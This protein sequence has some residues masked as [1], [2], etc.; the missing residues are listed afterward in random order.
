MSRWFQ[1]LPD[2]SNCIQRDATKFLQELQT[3][4]FYVNYNSTPWQDSRE[5]DEAQEVLT[6]LSLVFSET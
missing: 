4:L 3:Q 1:M 5:Y 2:E 6:F